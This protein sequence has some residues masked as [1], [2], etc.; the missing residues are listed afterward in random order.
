VWMW[1]WRSKPLLMAVTKG[2]AAASA[3][4]FGAGTWCG[5]GCGKCFKLTPTAVGASPLGRGA[6]NL[7]PLVIKVTN[8]C[9]YGG[10]EQW[11]AYDINS[12]GYDAHFDIMDYNMAGL[13]SNMGWDNPEVTYE[14]V[15]CATNG[16]EDWNCQC[17]DYANSTLST[18]APTA[19]PTAAPTS[20]PATKAPT[21]APATKAPATAA[22][23]T[24]APTTAVPTTKAPATAA[25]AT[26]APTT[27]APT[28]AAP[29]THTTHKPKPSKA[30]T[31]APTSAPVIDAATSVPTT[32]AATSAPATDA[33]VSSIQIQ[34]NGGSNAWWLGFS[35]IGDVSNIAKVEITDNS[36][37]L[38]FWTL[39]TYEGNQFWNMFSISPSGQQMKA[40]LSLRFTL[41]SGQ[42]VTANNIIT[43]FQAATVDTGVAL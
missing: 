7:T 28:T 9:P 20:A 16:Y 15:D 43:T 13:V 36:L 5:T 1:Y 38:P 33:P 17:K 39:M 30:A 40:P 42:V 19:T 21:A 31:S 24:K 2:T 26:E 22:P 32:D 27:K 10:N 18:D 4:I 8:L 12:Y 11:C 14:E 35:V 3:P 41:V 6:P 29:T 23:T 25:P 37:A 34:I